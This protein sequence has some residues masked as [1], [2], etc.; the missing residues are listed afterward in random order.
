YTTK[1]ATAAPPS[2]MV[3]NTSTQASTDSG[4]TWTDLSLGHATYKFKTAL[5]AGFDQTK[6]TTLAIYG[7]RELTDILGKDYFANVEYDFRPDGQT[8]TD[9]WDILS[10]AA[11]N[12]CH[13]PLSAHGGSRR[14][15]KLCV[16]CHSPTTV[17][18]TPNI[19]P[20][21]GNTI[22]FK[23]MIH[24]I[25]MGENL[26]SVVAGTPYVIIGFNQSVNDF[27]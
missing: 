15:V 4:G 23:V 10:N 7:T 1:V 21:T 6:T 12:T 17:A 27:S 18:G 5:P 22:D 26:P 20:D 9:K 25:H 3:G 13:N 14:D 2:T 24:K 19:D 8:I 16:T 11:C